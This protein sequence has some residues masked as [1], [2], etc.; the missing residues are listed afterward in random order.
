MRAILF[1]ILPHPLLSRDCVFRT[2][3][4][5]RMQRWRLRPRCLDYWLWKNRGGRGILDC[6][7]QVTI[8]YRVHWMHDSECNL[9]LSLLT[10]L[11]WVN[12]TLVMS[13]P[14]CTVWH[15]MPWL[16]FRQWPWQRVPWWPGCHQIDCGSINLRP[17]T[18]GW[19]HASNSLSWT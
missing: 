9:I 11:C 12:C 5:S 14:T 17:N 16:P 13:R 7:K 1:A 4:W 8:V 15:L 19:A 18:S 6:K 2:I 10:V 3:R